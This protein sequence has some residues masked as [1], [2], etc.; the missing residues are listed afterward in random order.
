VK[1][2][3][4]GKAIINA[5]GVFTNSIMKLNDTVYKKYIVPSQGI[6][7]VFDKSFAKRLCVDD[8]KQVTEGFICS[9]LAQQNSSGNNR[10]RNEKHSIDYCLET[11]IEFVLETAQR[12]LVKPTRADVLCFAGYDH[13]QQDEPGKNTKIS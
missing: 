7:L 6:H 12:Y 8:S 10:Y 4:K 3:N 11:E 1:A 5:T 9:A 13:W 2:R